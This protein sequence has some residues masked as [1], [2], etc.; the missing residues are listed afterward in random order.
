MKTKKIQISLRNWTFRPGPSLSTETVFGYCRILQRTV[1][2][3][4]IRT[5]SSWMSSIYSSSFSSLQALVAITFP[6]RKS[7]HYTVL[8]AYDDLPE[9][10]KTHP[11]LSSLFQLFYEQKAQGAIPAHT[12]HRTVCTVTAGVRHAVDFLVPRL[13]N[14]ISDSARLRTQRFP[15]IND[16]LDS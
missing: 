2:A 3:L 7:S 4:V 14:C 11:R 5:F 16:V 13:I 1:E 6:T 12:M 15:S 8:H 10:P 9:Q